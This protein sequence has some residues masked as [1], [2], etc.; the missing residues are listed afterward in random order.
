MGASRS[1]RPPARSRSTSISFS[2]TAWARRPCGWSTCGS[3]WRPRGSSSRKRP[4][5][6]YPACIGVVTSAQGAVWHDIQTIIARRYPN[7]TLVLAP[8]LVQGEAAPASIVAALRRLWEHGGCDV[9]IVGRGGGS[10]EDLW[11]FNDEAVARAIYAS[12]VPIVSAVG[13]EVDVTIA[14]HVADLRAPTPSAAAEL[15]VPDGRQLL[16]DVLLLRERLQQATREQVEE[17]REAVAGM[18]ARLRRAS[19]RHRVLQERQRMDDLTRGLAV[20][21][22]HQLAL[23]RQAVAAY[24]ARLG[25]LDP[26]AVLGRGYAVVSTVTTNTLVSAATVETGERLRVRV[27]DGHFLV[28]VE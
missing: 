14:D 27:R 18:L 25:A 15:V 10:A 21:L 24:Q 13:H 19:P 2:R 20:P 3:A 1:T 12:P 22:R 5:P 6:T 23:R 17:R 11:A 9:I 16:A 26:R 7:V 4:L 28:Q 8:S